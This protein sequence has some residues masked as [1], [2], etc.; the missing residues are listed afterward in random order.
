MIFFINLDKKY[1]LFIG[2][3][4]VEGETEETLDVYCPADGNLL[5]SITQAS[6]KDVDKAVEAAWEGFKEYKKTNKY[7]RAEILNKIADII[8]ENADHLAMVETLDNGSLET[9]T[10]TCSRG[11]CCD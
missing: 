10:S 1:G 9:F 11:C 5:S 2:G 7:E 6:E 3:E 8:D 4:F